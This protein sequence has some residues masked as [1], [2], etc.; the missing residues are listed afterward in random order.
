MGSVDG[1]VKEEVV[2]V[3][4]RAWLR[5]RWRGSEGRVSVGVVVGAAVFSSCLM[6]G[7]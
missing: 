7:V 6:A 4:V 5:G 2:V 1:E 3:I